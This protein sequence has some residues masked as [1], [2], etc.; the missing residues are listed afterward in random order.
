MAFIEIGP[1]ENCNR[2][3]VECLPQFK[4][5]SMPGMDQSLVVTRVNDA[6][7]GHTTRALAA[8]AEKDRQYIR[9]KL[10]QSGDAIRSRWKK[11]GKDKREAMILEAQS[12]LYR[13]KW[14]ELRTMFDYDDFTDGKGF[15][16]MDSRDTE[17]VG[18]A[19]SLNERLKNSQL[20]PYLNIETLKEDPMRLL[21]LLHHRSESKLEDWVMFDL[22]QMKLSVEGGSISRHYNSNCVVMY[23]DKYGELIMWDRAQCHRWN[24][25]G[26]PRAVLVLEA[27]S[28]LLGFL[29]R[30]V[31]IIAPQ[32]AG[33]EGSTEWSTLAAAGFKSSGEVEYWST[34]SNQA[35]SAPPTFDP[36]AALKSARAQLAAAEDHLRFLQTD[37]VY[38]QNLL[39]KQ[40]RGEH[41]T[42]MPTEKVWKLLVADLLVFPITH[43]R[44]LRNVVDECKNLVG[45]YSTYKYEINVGQAL[46]KEYERALGALELLCI[47][48][49]QGERIELEK[50]LPTV[51]GFHRNY[52]Y[53]TT[54]KGE[55]GSL[56]RNIDNGADNKDISE[57]YFRREPLYYALINLCKN[58]EDVDAIRV[59][60]LMGF[61]DDHLAHANSKERARID[62]KL[63]D[64]LARMS[65]YGEIFT[66]LR[67][68]R[69]LSAGF[70]YDT[71]TEEEKQRRTWRHWRCTPG[72]LTDGESK[73]VSELLLALYETP[74]PAGKKDQAWLDRAA[75]ARKHLAAFWTYARQVRRREVADVGFTDADIEE[76]VALF[77]ADQTEE[78]TAEATAETEMV[79]KIIAAEAA[80]KQKVGRGAVQTS[81]GD[82][83]PMEVELPVARMK[84]KTRPEDYAPTASIDNGVA[85]A[86]PDADAEQEGQRIPVKAESLRIFAKMFPSSAAVVF[87][88]AVR[89]QQFVTAMADAGCSATHTGGSAVSFDQCASTGA[90][91]TIVF[92]KP[93]PDP[94]VDAVMLQTM[95]KRLRKWFG[96]DADVFVEREKGVK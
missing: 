53:V 42:Q 48:L 55:H 58:P 82:T 83:K 67:M 12:N 95:G 66:A 56:L 78:Y 11:K 10:A 25:I 44:Q 26:Y 71:A 39:G 43:V 32:D 68:T 45:L 51:P 62:Q 40:R 23:G 38:I 81:W 59:P 87:K 57:A 17:A 47:N 50:I 64:H 29:R 6:T 41:F 27:Q 24:C 70:A 94:E 35:F 14:P 16:S 52:K 4:T 28:T 8:D 5:A 72:N 30:V 3:C 46:P 15:L 65:V 80:K 33:I 90:G 96:W 7:A 61:I 73:K 88:G 77:A 13:D 74:M 37:A 85:E 60:F 91:G 18:K 36:E 1:N 84:P 9:A 31:D 69:P 86:A 21:S 22:Q 49:Y 63:Y 20:L 75:E 79:E 76:N 89:W 54:S 2:D 92:H 34:F 93:H 19:Q